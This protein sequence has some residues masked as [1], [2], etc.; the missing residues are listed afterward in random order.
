[1]HLCQDITLRLPNGAAE[2]GDFLGGQRGICQMMPER[3]EIEVEEHI[4][5]EGVTTQLKAMADVAQAPG[6][7]LALSGITCC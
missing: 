3:G 4:A 2:G 5:A 7:L 6:K 1:M